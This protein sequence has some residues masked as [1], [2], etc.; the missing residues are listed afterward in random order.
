VVK[1]KPHPLFRVILFDAIDTLNT[2]IGLNINGC[3][4]PDL[5][6]RQ[7]WI[8]IRVVYVVCTFLQEYFANEELSRR[9]LNQTSFNSQFCIAAVLVLPLCLGCW[10]DMRRTIF[11][12]QKWV[13][14]CYLSTCYTVN[15]SNTVRQPCVLVLLHW[16]EA[17]L[18]GTMN[19]FRC[20]RVY[21][22]KQVLKTA[23]VLV[24]W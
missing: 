2:L 22:V 19:F 4:F 8:K 1:H 3:S 16:A 21:A 5:W 17:F 23:F 14:A 15:Q 12:P 10:P 11:G 7:A 9:N 13:N 20:S 18:H 24:V 6:C